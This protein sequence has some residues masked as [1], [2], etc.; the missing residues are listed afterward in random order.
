MHGILLTFWW[1]ELT[2]DVA[3]YRIPRFQEKWSL[4]MTEDHPPMKLHS[5]FLPHLEAAAR[6]EESI[7]CMVQICLR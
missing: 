2:E 1:M 6:H 7:Y 4:K 3:V 5:I